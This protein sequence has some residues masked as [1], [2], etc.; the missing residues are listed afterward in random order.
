MDFDHF[1]RVVSWIEKNSPEPRTILAG[2]HAEAQAPHRWPDD[3]GHCETGGNLPVCNDSDTV[4]KG[5]VGAQEAELPAQIAEAMGAVWTRIVTPATVF[6]VHAALEAK[7]RR[8]LVM[9]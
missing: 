5:G 3:T 7:L 9:A 1:S 2:L 8:R 4:R 6:A